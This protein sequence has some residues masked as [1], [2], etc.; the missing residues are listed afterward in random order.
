MFDPQTFVEKAN[1]IVEAG[2]FLDAMGWVPATSG[3]FSARLDANHAALTA[4]GC[5]KG[6]LTPQQILAVDMAGRALDP[7]AKPS[8]ETL[9]HT[10]LY[11]CFPEAQAV[12]HTHSVKGTVLSKLIPANTDLTLANYE[13]LKALRGISTHETSLE[14]HVFANTQDMA[15]LAEDLLQLIRKRERVPGFLIQGHGLY[16]WGTSMAEAQRHVEAFEFLFDCELLI[17][18]I[19]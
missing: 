2:R 12:L 17:R 15:A 6:R 11:K 13:M 1:D 7:A 18:R 9:L 16:T 4:S 5:H 19:A 8:A 3:N 10:T 14:I